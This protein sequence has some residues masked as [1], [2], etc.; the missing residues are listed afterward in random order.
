L[1]VVVQ[2]EVYKLPQMTLKFIRDN[3]VID[4]SRPDTFLCVGMRGSGKSSVLETLAVHYPKIIDLFGS[5]DHES[6]AWCKPNSPYHKVLFIVG[7][8][9]TV[10][11]QYPTVNYA[12]LTLKDIEKYEVVTTC[13]AFYNTKAEYYNAIQT[14]TTML[15]DKRN[16]WL[17]PWALVIRES[18]NYIYSRLQI[19]KDS[20]MAKA[21]FIALL[22]E[23]R[24]SGIACLVDTIRWT[25]LDKEVRDVSDFMFFKRVGAIGLPKDLHFLYRY[26]NPRSFMKLWKNVFVLMTGTGA[27]AIGKFDKVPWHKEEKEDIL[28]ELGINIIPLNP[29]LITA[30]PNV[31]PT[32]HALIVRTYN[33]PKGSMGKT[34]AKL[35][36]SKSTIQ[37]AIKRHNETIE[38]IDYC[39][40]CRDAKEP[41]ET[42]KLKTKREHGECISL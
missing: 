17:Q 20:N 14:V 11:S 38:E 37:A 23:A 39:L 30:G 33:E 5:K 13:H 4:F 31:S 25:S 26:V 34:A 22:R 19:V 9:I 16:F 7:D 36:R 18:A 27:I 12:S 3:D 42:T 29:H 24:H 41:L 28:T 32:E 1:T 15:C 6:L 8:N 2:P 10:S 21:D 40:E 35:K